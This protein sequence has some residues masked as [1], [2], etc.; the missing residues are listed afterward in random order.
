ML[1]CKPSHG[2]SSQFGMSGPNGDLMQTML[3]ATQQ[4]KG[5][6]GPS[7]KENI[8]SALRVKGFSNAQIADWIDH[9]MYHLG[10]AEDAL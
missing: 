9:L 4:F 7:T 6:A 1:I 10:Y 3:A 5:R 8:M 2:D